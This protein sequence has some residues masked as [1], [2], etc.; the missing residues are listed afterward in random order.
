MIH[1]SQILKIRALV[2]A[3]VEEHDGFL[4]VNSTAE[5]GTSFY[6]YFPIV[7]E[8]TQ[9]NISNIEKERLLVGNEKIM[10]VDDEKPIRENG[11]EF[12]EN[13]GYQ[14]QTYSN[15]IEAFETF[16]THTGEFDL[17]I[18]DMTMPGLNGYELA[19]KIL[20]LQ[21]DIPIILCTGFYMKT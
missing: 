3:I 9:E 13:F 18:T 15:G 10:F 8:E 5:K 12:L 4:V 21:P 20:K 7:K 16:K 6:V 14:V 11:K 2:Q 1:H 17:I 19:S